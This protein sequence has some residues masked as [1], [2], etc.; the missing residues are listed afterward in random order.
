MED[1]Q[2]YKVMEALQRAGKLGAGSH[3][4]MPPDDTEL[5]RRLQM[6][7]ASGLVSDVPALVMNKPKTIINVANKNSGY[8]GYKKD[9]ELVDKNTQELQRLGV[10]YEYLQPLVLK[11]RE[12]QS[13]VHN[14]DRENQEGLSEDDHYRQINELV[15]SLRGK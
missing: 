12:E 10:P 2:Y 8:E 4:D 11:K 3:G 1:D 15:D 13:M 9:T 14:L 6:A 5:M 7:K